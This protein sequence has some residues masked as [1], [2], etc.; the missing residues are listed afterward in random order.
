MENELYIVGIGPGVWDCLTKEAARV[1]EDADCVVAAPRNA[2]LAGRHGNVL[3]LGDFSV[4]FERITE[5][6]KKGTVAVLVS[7]DPGMY[8]L[9]PLIKRRFSGVRLKIIPG[10]SAL[11][12]LCCE[13]GESWDGAFILSGHGRFVSE[14]RLLTTADRN[15][16]TIF[17][18]GADKTPSWVCKTLAVNGLDDVE[19]V[20][21]ERLSYPDQ[22]ISSGVPSSLVNRNFDPLSIV[23]I[24]NRMPWT[25]PSGRLRDEAFIRS[26]VPMTKS[27]ARSLIL[28]RLELTPDAVFWDIG[29]G[30]GSVSVSAALLYPESEIYAVES[31]RQAVELIKKNREKFHCFNIDVRCYKCP[32]GMEK[33][34]RPTH[35]FIGGSGGAMREI[36]M[37][38]ASCGG[39]IKVV[40]SAVSLRTIYAAAEILEG[41][42]YTS[43]EVTQLTVSK[44]KIVGNDK[45]IM[46]AHNPIMIFSALTCEKERESAV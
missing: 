26:H 23:L 10:I 35:V 14:S 12:S 25:A 16:K 19:V 9:L 17:F 41:L 44:S 28:D 2:W 32:T 22:R 39:G 37:A 34:P 3:P 36:L 38:V 6:L 40:L 43:L 46:T 13:A 5:E 15:A 31:D 33:L 1:I 21:G 29:A 27:E 45:R 18:C 11:Q 42:S 8:S 24:C 7:G 30:T 4:A 20:V